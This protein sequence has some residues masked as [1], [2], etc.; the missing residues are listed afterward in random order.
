MVEGRIVH[1]R[2]IL[3]FPQNHAMSGRIDCN[4]EHGK[5]KGS[6]LGVY[7]WQFTAHCIIVTQL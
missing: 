2:V 1:Q 7:G 5:L 3:Q 4:I 6:Y